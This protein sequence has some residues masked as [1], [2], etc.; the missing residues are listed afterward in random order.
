METEFLIIGAGLAGLSA[1]FHLK[2]RDHVIVEADDTIGGLCKTYLVD[3]FH[4]DC[5]GHLI[6]F[7]TP[8]GKKILMERVGDRVTQHERK[9]AIF[10]H[11]RYTDYPFQ[12]NTYGL[13]PETIKDCILGFMQTLTKKHKGGI[14]NF[15]DWI[16]DTFGDGIA[17]HFMVPYNEKIWQHDLRDIDLDW[18][19]WSIPKPNLEEV[20][21]GAL[22]IKNRQFGYNPVFFYPT[23]GGISTLPNS[24]TVTGKL[25]LSD[26]VAKIHLKKRQVTL[27]TGQIIRYRHLLSTMPL[28]SFLKLVDDLSGT[29]ASAVEKLKYVS[30]LNINLGIDREGVVPYHWIYFPEKDKPF[31]RVGCPSNFSQSVAPKGTSSLFAEVSLRPEQQHDVQGFVAQTVDALKRCKILREDDRIVTVHPI[32]L[33]VAYVIYNTDR[34]KTVARIQRML[35]K[36]AVH[37]FGRYGSW[38]Y[39]SMEDAILQGKAAAEQL[40]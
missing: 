6:H 10:I 15:H 19:N 12:A 29:L 34:R 26:P 25:I 40:L 5:T 39:S 16:Y 28:H 31:Y 7:R 37:S 21:N 35:N 8:E 11:D 24:F 18:V 32:L 36:R 38:E 2:G 17:K 1:G 13:P 22:G 14:R 4:F 9:A 27:G 23:E 33:K 20:L 30:V 3:G